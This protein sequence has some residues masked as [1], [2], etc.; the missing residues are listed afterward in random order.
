[1]AANDLIKGE[2]DYDTWIDRSYYQAAVEALAEPEHQLTTG[3]PPRAARV[4]GRRGSEPSA[5]LEGLFALKAAS[6]RPEPDDRTPP[7]RTARGP[8]RSLVAAVFFIQLLDGTIIATS[9]PQM[10]ADLRHRRRRARRRLHRLPADHGGLHP[11][12]RLARRPL[13]RRAR[14][15]SPPSSPSPPPR[16]LCGLVDHAPRLRRRPRAAGRGR[17]ADGAGRPQPRSAEHAR[18]P[19]SCRRSPPSP[20]RRSPRRSSARS[21]AAG[22]PRT[23]AGSGTSTSTCRS[24]SPPPSSSSP[25]SRASRDPSRGRFDWPGFLLVSGAWSSPSPGLEAFVGQRIP[26]PAPGCSSRHRV[27]AGSPSATCAARRE[28]LFDLDVLAV[29]ILRPRHPRPPAPS[30]ASRSTPRPS[31]CRSS[32]RSASASRAVETG[33]LVLVYFLG[34]LAMKSVTTP[35]MRRFGFRAGPDRQRAPPRRHDRRLRRHP[36]RPGAPAAPR[37]PLRRRCDA[38][39]AVHRA[40]HP[41]LRRHRRRRSA[42]PPRPSRACSSRSAMV[43]GVALAV[44]AVRL[45]QLLNGGGGDPVVA[46][47]RRRLRGD[48]ADRRRERR[49]A[50]SAS[51]PRPATRS[52]DAAA[53]SPEGRHELGSTS[54]LGA[55]RAPRLC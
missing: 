16:S 46:D 44:A 25:S 38:L 14:S 53:R 28:P 39:D 20:G 31:C 42:A 43:L 54:A 40:Q 3:W 29:P 48:G 19:A 22:S 9:L 52:P 5:G 35:V 30:A 51:I 2:V 12:R 27:S 45:A 23:S 26:P 13:R 1:M 32:S 17:R 11:A 34:N 37:A 4:H 49:S 21:S 50:S 36:G 55:A 7:R 24:A 47:F 18:S 10:A 6:A 33:S 41:R 15:S 8:S